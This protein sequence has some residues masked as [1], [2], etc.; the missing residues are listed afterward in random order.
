MC[1]YLSSQGYIVI[2]SAVAM[3]EEVSLWVCENIKNSMQV[4]LDV[5]SEIRLQRDART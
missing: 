1:S 4:Y 3:F 2:I 5:P